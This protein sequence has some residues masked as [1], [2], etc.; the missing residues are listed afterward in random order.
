MWYCEQDVNKMNIF[1]V[2][3]EFEEILA[4]TYAKKSEAGL[5][6]GTGQCS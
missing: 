4:S 2:S 1:L 6:S 3:I 5:R